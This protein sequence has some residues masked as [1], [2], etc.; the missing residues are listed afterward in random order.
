MSEFRHSAWSW[1]FSIFVALVIVV[2]VVVAFRSL[3]GWARTLETATNVVI[4]RSQQISEWDSGKDYILFTSVRLGGAKVIISVPIERVFVRVRTDERD[5]TSL[6]GTY[7]KNESPRW[8]GGRLNWI[9]ATIWV[10]NESD[11]KLWEQWLKEQNSQEFRRVLP[12][13]AK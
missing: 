11:K 6:S 9:E 13:N 5:V 12:P 4:E 8:K 7:R 10:P 2:L 3:D 1:P